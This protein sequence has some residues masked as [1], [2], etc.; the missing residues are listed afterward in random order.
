[1]ADPVH[2]GL[3]LCSM[4]LVINS[5]KNELENH[6]AARSKLYYLP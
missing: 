4:P 5:K 3:H 1:M 2:Q 6:K